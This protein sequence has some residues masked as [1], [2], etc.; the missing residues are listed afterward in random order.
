MLKHRFP[1]VHSADRAGQARLGLGVLVSVLLGV[2][3]VLAPSDGLSLSDPE[4]LPPDERPNDL[5]GPWA[6]VTNRPECAIEGKVC[7]E[8]PM[9][10]GV[11]V[12]CCVDPS[13]IGMFVIPWQA[14]GSDG[15]L[16]AGGRDF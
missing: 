16:T 13:L 8:W 12:L 6:I 9:A 3:T 15:G 7:A 14:C 2:M 5:D 11:S 4:L 10:S 1:Y